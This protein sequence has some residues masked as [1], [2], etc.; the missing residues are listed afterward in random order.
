MLRLKHRTRRAYN[1]PPEILS[2]LDWKS[3]ETVERPHVW[4]CARKQRENARQKIMHVREW[5]A[6]MC[7]A[8]VPTMRFEFLK[9]LPRLKGWI[10]TLAP[11]A[12]TTQRCRIMSVSAFLKFIQRA[13]LM[14]VK[15]TTKSVKSVLFFLENGPYQGQQV[16]G[17][18]QAASPGR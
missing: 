18:S 6:F 3:P 15:A 5:M 11:Y 14:E 9:D 1:Y 2:D 4:R 7:C 12:V 13:D 8:G 17:R 16:R 10:G